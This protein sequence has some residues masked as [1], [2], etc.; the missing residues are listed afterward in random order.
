ME[1]Y[2]HFYT[3]TNSVPTPGT[4]FSVQV[5]FQIPR[6][7]EVWRSPEKKVTRVGVR[8]FPIRNRKGNPQLRTTVKTAQRRWVLLHLLS[9][10]PWGCRIWNEWPQPGVAGISLLLRVLYLNRE[11]CN[12][13]ALSN[14]YF[15]QQHLYLLLLDD[16]A[17][18][19]N[20]Q[21]LT[22]WEHLTEDPLG[23]NKTDRLY[24]PI[25][26]AVGKL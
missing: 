1:N 4:Q 26:H 2:T 11:S 8:V 13:Q 5:L 18:F 17:S 21:L 25:Q 24:R 6:Q 7:K 12:C 14:F 22:T 10:Y 23:N 19:H 9:I 20:L 16:Q 15:Q 3:A